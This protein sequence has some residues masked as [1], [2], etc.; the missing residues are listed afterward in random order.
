VYRCPNQLACNH[1]VS[2]LV[3]HNRYN[4]N[5]TLVASSWAEYGELLC[6]RSGYTGLLCASC[7]PGYG[8]TDAFMC[9]TCIQ[10]GQGEVDRTKIWACMFG[11]GVAF[12]LL[13]WFTIRSD[14][15]ESHSQGADVNSQGMQVTDVIKALT[16]YAQV[17]H[18]VL[19]CCCNLSQSRQLKCSVWHQYML[20]SCTSAVEMCTFPQNTCFMAQADGTACQAADQHWHAV[21]PCKQP[22]TCQD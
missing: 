16:M 17:G 20:C 19:Q 15:Q 6:N 11:Y 4:P 1:T 14:V 13:I 8:Q 3:T 22:Y 12:L 2:E 10:N 7:K 9:D 18:S 5:I 21:L